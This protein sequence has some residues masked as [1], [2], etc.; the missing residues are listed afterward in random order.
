MVKLLNSTRE[1]SINALS[2]LNSFGDMVAQATGLNRKL[3][4]TDSSDATARR[5]LQISN[6]K[7]NATVALDGSGQYKTIKEALDAVPKKNTEP[8]IIFIKA[9]VYKEYIDIPKS[10]TNVVL[11]GEGPTKTKITGNKSVKDGPSTF[12]TTTVG[13]NGANF[14]AKNIGFE[15]TAGP[16]KEQAVA[17][18]VS[19]DKAIIYNC[20]IDGYQDTLY[21]HTYRQFYRDCT[22]TGTVDFI[23][24]N[25]EAVLQNCKVIV[26]KPAQNQSCMVTAQ[27]RTE[28]IQK[29]AIVL[30]NCEIKPDT[31]YFSL[32]PPSKTYLG[33]PWKEYSRT[34]IMQSYID[35][36]IEPEG[37]APW[38]ITN[39]GRDTSYY[40]E[41]QNRG[42]GAALDKRITWKGFQKGFTGEA[43]QK[44]TAGVYINND[45][46]WLQKANV[47]YEAGMMKV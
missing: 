34:I 19:A 44:F 26:R 28:P 8:F 21:V 18:R 11:I 6:A 29:G 1:L 43:A 46:N 39:F 5:L 37:W 47:P 33:R 24:G 35:K 25:G 14:V 38:N 4:T 7:P 30:Q 17:L 2:M 13:V 9:G 23:F 42:P 36:F 20:Q 10:M 40:A 22:I 41:Y 15:N 12:H 32:S 27:G 16:E 45:E 31:D 3:L